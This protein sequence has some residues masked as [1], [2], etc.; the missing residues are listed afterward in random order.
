MSDMR[1]PVQWGMKS[2][3]SKPAFL[4]TWLKKIAAYLEIDDV[5]ETTPPQRRGVGV[6]ANGSA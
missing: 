4:N 6:R 5:R 3:M 1:H 2:G